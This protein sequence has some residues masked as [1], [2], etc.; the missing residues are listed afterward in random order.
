[1]WVKKP[2]QSGS[3]RSEAQKLGLWFALQRVLISPEAYDSGRF[4]PLLNTPL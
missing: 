2:D 4:R 3:P 1:M